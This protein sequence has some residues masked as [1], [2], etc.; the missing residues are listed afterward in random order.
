[1]KIEQPGA[2]LD[3][4]L[5]QTR[6]HHV[7]LSA[8]A[9]AKANALMTMSAVITTF[10]A[11]FVVRPG[12]QVAVIVLMCFNLATILLA[13]FSVMPGGQIRARKG[14]PPA[15]LPAHSN[16]L[17]FGTFV[18]L[19]YKQYTALMEEMMNDH[20]K[21]YEAQVHEIYTLGCYLA[22]KKFRYLRYAYLCFISGLFASGAALVAMNFGG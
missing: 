2:Y 5:R 9:D 21:T 3:Q 15:A 11:S 22:G 16:I 20:S 17:F 6:A 8:M 4:M 14:T 1:V 13:T 10:A 12:F 19:E 7:Q 18:N